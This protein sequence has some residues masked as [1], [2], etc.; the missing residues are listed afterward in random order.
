MSYIS[1]SSQYG[2][3]T[4]N[5]CERKLG[6][7]ICND[8]MLEEIGK[9][10]LAKDYLKHLI[11]QDSYIQRYLETGEMNY[12]PVRTW[13]EAGRD[14]FMIEGQLEPVW[15]IAM[16]TAVAKGGD[17][18]RLLARLHSQ[19]E[20]HC[21]VEGKNR[22]WL[23]SIIKD[24]LTTILRPTMGWEEVM[25]L[26]ESRDDCP[27][28]CSFS[29]CEGFPCFECLPEGHDLLTPLPNEEDEDD[30]RNKFYNLPNEK[31]WELCM[32]YL[33]ANG[34]IENGG[35][36]LSPESLPVVNFGRG[37]T[38]DMLRALA[39]KDYKKKVGTLNGF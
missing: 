15:Y 6:I 4:L 25:T 17:V 19:C 13:F 31:G 30:R 38:A 21:F 3:A 35:L 28:V 16:N 39:E 36:E 14:D 11:P 27:V 26:L 37:Y 1:F 22:K 20:L 10:E 29:V 12:E 24:G 34:G 9:I 8:I 23:A 32:K 33:R 5:N 7:K 18:V 2:K